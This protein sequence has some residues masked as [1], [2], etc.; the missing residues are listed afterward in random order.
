MTEAAA[1]TAPVATKEAAAPKIEQNGV[2]RPKA[3]TKTARVWEIADSLSAAAG[4]PA[5]RKN[6]LEATAAEQINAATT[7][8]Q[9]GR[10]A[11]FNGLVLKREPK[12]AVEVA[13]PAVEGE[14]A[15]PAGVTVE[16]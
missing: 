3:G 8:T 5:E 9:F 12:V 7:S 6:V 16:E 4:K 14:V 11:K 15:A 13:P 2:V 1:N 10:W